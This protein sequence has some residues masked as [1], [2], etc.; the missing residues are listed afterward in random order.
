MD[1]SRP[2]M[3]KDCNQDNT[4]EMTNFSSIGIASRT[5]FKRFMTVAVSNA[6]LFHVFFLLGHSKW[7]VIQIKKG[8]IASSLCIKVSH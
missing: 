3:S 2:Q 7:L 8:P 5:H 6:G 1:D 4:I